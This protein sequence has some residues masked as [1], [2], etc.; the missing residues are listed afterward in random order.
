MNH[1]KE[2]ISLILLIIFLNSALILPRFN[3]TSLAKAEG[4]SIEFEKF[5]IN[6]IIHETLAEVNVTGLFFNPTSETAIGE[7]TIQIPVGAYV[8]NISLQTSNLTYWGRIMKKEEAQEAF[9]NAT[10]SN[11]SA[12]LL[13]QIDRDLFKIEYSVEANTRIEITLM[14]FKRIT[15]YKGHYDLDIDLESIMSQNPQSVTANYQILSPIRSI[16]NVIAPAGSEVIEHSPYHVSIVIS[17]YSLSLGAITLS[18]DLTGAAFGSNIFAYN[19]G[20]NEFFVAT[21]SP[22]L[23]EVGTDRLPKDFVFIIDVSG[24]M[25]GQKI[26]QARTALINIIDRLHSDDRFGVVKFNH[27]AESATQKL[28]NCTNVND[29]SFVKSWVANLAASS[30]TNIH[31]ALLTGLDMFDSSERLAILVLLTDGQP[32]TGI[33][34][35]ATIEFEFQVANTAEVSLFTLGFGNDVDFPFLQRIARQ[36]AGEAFKIEENQDATEQLTDFYVSVSTPVM[37]NINLTINSGVT[38]NVIYPYFIPNLFDGSEIF[39]VGEREADSTVDLIIEGIS[40]DGEV[41]YRILLSAPSSTS[42]QDRWI[43]E[44][45]AIAK[46]DDLLTKIEYGDTAN[47]IVENVTSMALFYGIVTPYTALFIDTTPEFADDT[48]ETTSAH[49]WQY[50]ATATATETA[51][52][53]HPVP[54]TTVETETATGIVTEM[55]TQESP[56]EAI[57]KEAGGAIPGFSW[58]FVFFTLIV[59]FGICKYRN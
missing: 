30:S 14:Y 12:L 11:R 34:D 50:T 3:R 44:T 10:V 31:Q 53:P 55:T 9:T 20:T 47:N 52:S 41:D 57:S 16:E 27:Y 24:S 2:I 54:G 42:P 32:T 40:A 8:S 7:F 51:T 28:V 48:Q 1:G 58:F 21:F 13:T 4:A 15:R 23:S 6:A 17:E 59:I 25:S 49:D 46:I 5:E 56:K 18:Y 45:W 26:D 22:S 33:T 37:T 39:L 38:D 29:V 35:T 43:E 36:N 19:N